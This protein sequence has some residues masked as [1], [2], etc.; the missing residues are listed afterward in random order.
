M[1]FEN[2]L[3]QLHDALKSSERV[4]LIGHQKP[5]GDALGSTSGFYSWLKREGKKPTLYCKDL[6][7]QQYKYLDAFFDYKD[8]IKVFD[9]KYDMVIMFDSGDMVYAGV[10]ALIPKLP[11]SPTLV[12]IDHHKTNQFYGDVNIVNVE[13]TSTCEVVARFFE[14]NNVLIDS[15]MATSLM[16]GILTDTSHFSN[17]ATTSQG[18]DVAGR[19]IASGARM[20][21]ITKY[22]LKNKELPILKIW[23]LALSR[24]HKNETQDIA[25]TF[26]TNEDFLKYGVSPNAVEG[27]SNFLQGVTGN[28]ES[29]L[30]LHDRGDGTIKGSMRSVT[31]DVSAIAKLFGGGGH[32]LAAGF[33]IKGTIKET[34]EGFEIN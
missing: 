7:A 10:D 23:G 14:A 25:V 16:T 21:E 8:D 9:M 26:V 33:A 19:L 18:M 29:I 5:D 15:T 12:N 30:V 34:K 17:A 1:N 32:K 24:L 31:R 28:A 11:N 6:P 13:A 27:I 22:L 3:K 2:R 4:L 20:N